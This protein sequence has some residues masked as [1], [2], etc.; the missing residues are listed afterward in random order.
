MDGVQVR[1]GD[2]IALDGVDCTVAPG[3]VEAVIGPDGAGKSTLARVLVGLVPVDGGRVRRPGRA[4]LGYQPESA[5]TWRDLT[6][7]EN[8][9]FV[10]ASRG[11]GADLDGRTRELVAVTDL[12]EVTDR[13]A[14]DL[15]GGMRQKLAVAMAM[16]PRPDLLV[17]DEPTTGLDPISRADVWRLLAR[18]AGEGAA[19]VVTTAYLDEAQRADH[20]VVLDHGRVLV[21]GTAREITSSFPGRLVS[22]D[23]RDP[24]RP[25]W[26][27]GRGW[28]TWDRDTSTGARPEH[29][30]E[31]DLDDVVMA[32]AIARREA[33]S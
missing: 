6:V 25:S 23:R 14:G 16:L 4:R 27:R 8:L 7:A 28:R 29:E 32:A 3:R 10:A 9:A 15:S 5:G 21:T 19:I 31:P 13:L 17:L 12:A 18:A 2:T 30:L 11:R 22:T 1:F 20:V 33:G 24:R 26:R